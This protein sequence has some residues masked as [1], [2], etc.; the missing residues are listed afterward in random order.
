MFFVSMCIHLPRR[1]LFLLENSD[2]IGVSFVGEPGRPSTYISA[3]DLLAFIIIL[4]YTY[5]GDN[6]N[7]PQKVIIDSSSVS[8]S[9]LQLQRSRGLCAQ[10]ASSSR[11]IDSKAVHDD[12]CTRRL[13]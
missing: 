5:R 4:L 9:R 3:T 11:L 6:A 8:V 2:T 12:Y 7:G 1:S 13:F 10:D